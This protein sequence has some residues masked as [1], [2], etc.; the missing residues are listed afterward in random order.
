MRKIQSILIIV[1][2]FLI[3]SACSSY[4]SFFAEEGYQE[5]IESSEALTVDNAS[6]AGSVN[7]TLMLSGN[8]GCYLEK[9]D[10]RKEID[11]EVPYQCIG[12]PLNQV[13]IG[14]KKKKKA[15]DDNV[16]AYNFYVFQS[17][18]EVAEKCLNRQLEAYFTSVN[19]NTK[20]AEDDISLVSYYPKW[21]MGSDRHILVKLIAKTN[22]GKIIEGTGKVVDGLGKGVA[23]W[24]FPVSILT[25]PVGYAIATTI[26]YNKHDALVNKMLAMAIDAA[27]ADLSKKIADEI[28][29]NP[30]QQFEVWV[31][32]E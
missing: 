27:A 24:Y 1:G 31:M 32:L 7:L 13:E 30:N 10:S 8:C 18:G 17:F 11:E 22:D 19:M 15:K 2:I 4:S 20:I 6:S 26:L 12:I 9:A 5:Y 29:L 23:Y 16:K 14:K 28:A 21:G 3:C 25:F